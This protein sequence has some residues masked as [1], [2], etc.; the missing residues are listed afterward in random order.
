MGIIQQVFLANLTSFFFLCVIGSY[1]SLRKIRPWFCVQIVWYDNCYRCRAIA[2]SFLSHGAFHAHFG[3]GFPHQ[4]FRLLS[5]ALA[6][7]TSFFLCDTLFKIIAFIPFDTVCIAET[8]GYIVIQLRIFSFPCCFNKTRDYIMQNFNSE[9]C[10]GVRYLKT[11]GDRSGDK[12]YRAFSWF[13]RF[14]LRLR[15]A[16]ERVTKSM[17]EMLLGNFIFETEIYVICKSKVI[18]MLN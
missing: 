2:A 16:E 10:F 12:K 1:D 9:R 14:R 6:K 5:L 8:L 4:E 7:N 18:P 13:E 17:W 11:K 3:D 15:W